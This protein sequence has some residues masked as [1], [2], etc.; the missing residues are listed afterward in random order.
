[1]KQFQFYYDL[2][3]FIFLL[4]IISVRSALRDRTTIS[5]KQNNVIL[6]FKSDPYNSQFQIFTGK[7]L[8]AFTSVLSINQCNQQL[9]CKCT[10]QKVLYLGGEVLKKVL[11]REAPPRGPTPYPFIYH[12]FSKG[13]SF[14][15]LLLEKGT[16]FIYLLKK[17]YE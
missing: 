11:Y 13:T 16:P 17:T 2:I 10:F 6:N 5:I 15:Y 7:T 12:F 4:R 8:I 3:E 9:Q 1:M 14:V